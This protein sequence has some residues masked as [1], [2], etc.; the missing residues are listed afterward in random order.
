MSISSSL[1]SAL[2]G[3]TAASRAAEVVSSNIA[4][5]MTP[6]YGRREVQTSSRLI[7]A[8]GQG[9][10]VTGI[11][12]HSDPVLIAE[13]RLAQAQAGGL[14]TGMDFLKR[15]EAALGTQD[16]ATSLNS[17]ISDFDSALIEA[18]SRPESEARLATVAQTAMALVSHVNTASATV[19]LARE[20]ADHQI[21]TDVSTVNSALASIAALNGQI[22]AGGS[23]NRDCSALMDQRQQM[24]DKISG[25]LPVRET[26][27]ENGQIALYTPGGLALLEGAP[28]VLGF[29][30]T[31]LI[32]PEMSQSG[33]GLSGLTLNGRSLSTSL[34]GPIGRGSLAA[35]FAIRDVAAPQAQDDLDGL[36]LDLI[37]R[38]AAPGLDQTRTPDAPGLFT[39]AGLAFSDGNVTGLALRLQLNAAVDPREGGANWRLRDGLGATTPGAVGN[40]ALLKDLQSALS[41]ERVAQS[42]RLDTGARSFAAFSSGIVSAVAARRVTAESEA[43]YS[44]AQLDALSV[45]E[46]EGGVDTDQEMQSLLLIEQAFSANAKVISTVGEMIQTLLAM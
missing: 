36:A 26:L 20:T 5:A 27:R 31:G 6:G 33:G 11:L 42:D 35:A 18:A 24:I 29:Q 46:Q 10:T 14:E 22:R 15:L 17:R 21:A 44:S 25:I 43:S 38:F 7:G 19:Q 28:A 32:V 45:M 37:E 23:G 40:A 8:T 13:R 34:D 16:S 3:L 39:D 2:S 4:N 41:Q 1:S 9:V 30:E 12:R